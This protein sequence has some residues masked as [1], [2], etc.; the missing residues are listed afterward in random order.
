MLASRH[1]SPRSGAIRVTVIAAAVG[2]LLWAIP[3]G[4]LTRGG[5]AAPV[6]LQPSGAAHAVPTSTA[7]LYHVPIAVRDLAA[8]SRVFQQL[9]FS[10]KAGA[11]HQDGIRNVHAKFPDGTEIELITAP[12]HPKS[13]AAKSYR[14]MIDQ[15]DGPAY[16][17]L[18]VRD[19]AQISQRL[20]QIGQG[21]ESN[22]RYITPTASGPLSYLFYA[23][24]GDGAMLNRSPTDRP[25]HFRHANG[26]QRLSAVWLASDDFGRLQ[27]LLASLGGWSMQEAVAAPAAGQALVANLGSS[28]VIMLPGT[29]Q[30]LPGRILIGL[31]VDV[32]DLA[33]TRRVLVR[34]KVPHTVRVTR[35]RRSLIVSPD[36]AAGTWLEFHEASR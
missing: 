17:A 2:G 19:L 24:D 16:M 22:P 18:Y 7:R 9:G 8:A 32:A 4:L 11:F 36:M 27:N 30:T 20:K 14:A 33:E 23:P 34:N 15:A 1:P 31:T 13:R 10:I 28:K 3:A 26:A 6:Q 35:T 25:E 12:E 21:H 5:V 29:H